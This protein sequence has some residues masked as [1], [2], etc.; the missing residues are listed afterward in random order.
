MTRRLLATYLL[1]TLVVLIALEVPLALGYRD[2]QMDQLKSGIERDAFVLSSYLSGSLSGGTPVDLTTVVAN[3][4]AATDGRVVIVNSTGDVLADSEPAAAG[5]RNFLSRPEIADALD[6]QIS[7]GTRYSTTLGTG[8]VYVAVPISIGDQVLGAIRV[9]YST[10]QVDAKVRR[11]WLVLLGAGLVTLLLAAALGVL[12]ARWVTR[13][14]AK[15]RDAANQLGDGDLSAR[16]DL[17]RGPPEIKDLA[18]AFNATAVRL[19]ELVTAQEQFVA[20]ASHQ[21]RTPLTALRLRLE[22]VELDPDD[23]NHGDIEGARNEVQRMSRLVDGLLALARAERTQGARPGR[24]EL[25]EA[26]QE[27]AAAWQPLATERNISIVANGGGLKGR[28]TSDMLSQVLD[29]LIANALEVA[30]AD[31]VLTLQ[32]TTEDSSSGSIIAVHVIDQGPGLSDEQRERAFDRF[33][34][35]TNERGELGGTG[36]GLAIVQKLVESEGGRAELRAAEGGG[37][38]AVLLLGN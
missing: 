11:Y 38:D 17:D 27:R 35:A 18:A 2:H 9:S 24:L 19:E 4:T 15:L 25:D 5:Q 33:W 6:R 13:P 28:C 22:M 23:A 37:L 29:N 36:L 34:R 3:Y 8:L 20:D 7:T 10:D 1:L 21:L 16:A 26:L 12:L 14:I 32:A 30:P 31:S